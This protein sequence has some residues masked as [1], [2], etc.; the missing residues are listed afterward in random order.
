[1]VDETL[2][3]LDRLRSRL[4]TEPADLAG[5]ALRAIKEAKRCIAS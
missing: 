4:G 5:Y 1:M 3:E 2:S